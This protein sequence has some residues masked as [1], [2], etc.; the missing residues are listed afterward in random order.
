MWKKRMEQMLRMWKCLK[1]MDTADDYSSV[2]ERCESGTER[3]PEFEAFV[4]NEMCQFTGAFCNSL[5]C[6]EMGYLCKVPYQ[7]GTLKNRECRF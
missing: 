7:I 5:H 1:D 6:D 3:I 4:L 2:R